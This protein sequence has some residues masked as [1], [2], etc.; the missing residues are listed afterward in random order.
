M[1]VVVWF[2][3]A[4][5]CEL[6]PET[7]SRGEIMERWL[8]K[9]FF[10]SPFLILQFFVALGIIFIGAIGISLRSRWGF[11][12]LLFFT[13]YWPYS[14]FASLLIILICLM[15]WTEKI[16]LTLSRWLNFVLSYGMNK[17]DL[18]GRLWKDARGP[19]FKGLMVTL[20]WNLLSVFA[21]YLG[22]LYFRYGW[23]LWIFNIGLIFIWSVLK[24]I[25]KKFA[26]RSVS[27]GCIRPKFRYNFFPLIHIIIFSSFMAFTVYAFLRET[28]GFDIGTF[29]KAD[30]P[31]LIVGWAF[32]VLLYLAIIK[33][34]SIYRRLAKLGTYEQLD[35]LFPESTCEKLSHKKLLIKR[36]RR[37]SRLQLLGEFLAKR[38]LRDKTPSSAAYYDETV[39]RFSPLAYRYLYLIFLNREA[40]M[41][42]SQN[43][44][45]GEYNPL[46]EKAFTYL[47]DIMTVTGES[48]EDCLTLLLEIFQ[49]SDSD[50]HLD[51]LR[52]FDK[53]NFRDDTVKEMP[54]FQ[55]H[56]SRE[57]E[58]RIIARAEEQKKKQAEAERE[59]KLRSGDIRAFLS[60][61]SAYL[62]DKKNQPL[63]KE[64]FKNYS[65]EE[66]PKEI[67]NYSA[68]KR[69]AIWNDSLDALF[70]KLAELFSK[71]Y[72]DE[73]LNLAN[74]AFEDTIDFLESF[75]EK[76][77]N[78]SA[79]KSLVGNKR[80]TFAKLRP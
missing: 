74:Y 24:V 64:F 35:E 53:A 40:G 48:V 61:D 4:M 72:D 39:R 11:D 3:A 28:A 32:V 69:Q 12:F 21:V 67:F 9:D 27:R 76:L 8:N 22:I 49:S 16:G 2:I 30:W 60:L 42:F 19:I 71:S 29:I 65:P 41:S 7:I 75:Y 25:N 43:K 62:G 63:L 44:T 1:I 77:L 52:P 20:A 51:L 46:V 13:D 54:M 55:A 56:L 33:R 34:K 37:S 59:E 70:K 23:N 78:K 38:W 47:A 31:Y 6:A 14:G 36:L 58:L 68:I 10:S 79:L 45:T 73:L 15:T 80:Q 17:A 5:A 66:M 57:E 50:L 26:I 18:G